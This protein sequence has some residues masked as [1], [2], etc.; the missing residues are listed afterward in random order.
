ME[1]AR[2]PALAGMELGGPGV[3][4]QDSARQDRRGRMGA[5]SPLG[6]AH[7]LSGLVW[8]RRQV[9]AWRSSWAPGRVLTGRPCLTRAERTKRSGPVCARGSSRGGSGEPGAGRRPSV[10]FGPRSSVSAGPSSRRP[11][12]RAS[13]A[14]TSAAA[15]ATTR[16]SPGAPRPFWP[17][18]TQTGP[19]WRGPQLHAPEL[20]PKPRLSA[21]LYGLLSPR[22]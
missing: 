18:S 16:C 15:A 4:G 6:A 12:L 8:R 9:P 17:P 20:V 13:A 3:A 7:S 1:P 2:R 21:L 22:P 14:D 11:H 5:G 19:A 10:I